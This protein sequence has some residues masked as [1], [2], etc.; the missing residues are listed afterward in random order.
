M[1]PPTTGGAGSS[2][3]AGF[4]SQAEIS[5]ARFGSSPLPFDVRTCSHSTRC[6]S[7][8]PRHNH[9]M[10]ERPSCGLRSN[11]VFWVQRSSMLMTSSCKARA[12]S[13]AFVDAGPGAAQ[14]ASLLPA[15]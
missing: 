6:R 7:V 3:S 1:K 5:T 4:G 13:A 12:T 10:R 2:G 11:S 15:H 8:F 9:R 14:E